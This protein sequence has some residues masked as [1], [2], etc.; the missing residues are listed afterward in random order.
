MRKKH[1]REMV[2]HRNI[3]EKKGECAIQK[4]SEDIQKKARNGTGEETNSR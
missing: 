3:L 2:Q 1:S 4:K